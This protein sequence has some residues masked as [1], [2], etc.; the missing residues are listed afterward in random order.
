MLKKLI[1]CNVSAAPQ[2]TEAADADGCAAD[3]DTAD[4][5]PDDDEAEE[6]LTFVQRVKRRLLRIAKELEMVTD[7]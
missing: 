2:D 1:T 6:K 3:A 5:T 7:D 4:G